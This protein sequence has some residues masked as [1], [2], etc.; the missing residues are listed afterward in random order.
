M[1]I[2]VAEYYGQRTDIDNPVIVPITQREACPFTS[3]NVCKKLRSGYH[4]VCSVRKADGTVYIVCSERLCSTKKDIPLCD[5]QKEML[6]KIAQHLYSPTVS[7]ADVC[8]KREEN[9]EVVEGTSYK[10]DYIISLA[11]G[12]SMFSGPDR[13]ILEM[14]GGGDTQDTGKSTAVVKA[15]ADNP[16]RTNELL[17][18]ESSGGAANVTGTWRRQ[19]EQFIVKGNI[20]MKTWKGYGIAF[21]VGSLMYDYIMNKLSSANLPNLRDFNWTLAIIAVK[22]DI[23]APIRSGPIP[24]IIDESK[25]F[26]TN[27]LTFIQALIN[28]GEPSLSAFR[29]QFINLNNEAVTVP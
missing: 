16:N 19:Q 26:F 3:G 28:Q 9:L 23:N 7:Y 8:V 12:R 17:R 1:G 11:T 20:A 25:M 18:R 15:W 21:C 24:L 10:A 6:H 14:Q 4:P 5:Y 27:Y 2:I 13:M 29:G 22:E